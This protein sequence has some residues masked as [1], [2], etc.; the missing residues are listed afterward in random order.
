MLHHPALDGPF[1]LPKVDVRLETIQFDDGEPILTLR[2]ELLD[3]LCGGNKL[4]KLDWWWPRLI[5]AGV[6][7]VIT[8]GGA[9]SQHATAVALQASRHGMRAH[10]AL[11][12][13]PPAQLSAYAFWSSFLGEVY[14]IE[15]DK[16]ADRTQTLESVRAKIESPDRKIAMI[17]E[18]GCA[19]EAVPGL[20]RLI[21]GL[22]LELHDPWR[23]K[24]RLVL[25]VA[26]AATASSIAIGIAA[27]GLPWEVYGVVLTPNWL[28]EAEATKTRLTSEFERAWGKLRKA[29]QIV[30]AERTPPRRFGKLMPEELRR[31]RTIAKSTG[32]ITDPLFTLAAL[33]AA[34]ASNRRTRRR[35]VLI[36]TGGLLGM[37]GIANRDPKWASSLSQSLT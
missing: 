1:L 3:P 32:Y 36:H 14:W 4:R 16:Y 29:P 13:E 34:L 30:W 35:T 27:M 6:T 8:C 17:A 28:E 31:S 25:D 7:D 33:D 19:V 26:T 9:Q 23:T 24:W 10:L 37:E 2:D 11:R 21:H 18:G 15:R 5:E 12:G 20:L 22:T